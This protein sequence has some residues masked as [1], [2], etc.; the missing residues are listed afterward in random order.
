MKGRHSFELMSKL[1]HLSRRQK[2]RKNCG[3]IVTVINHGLCSCASVPAA[4]FFHTRGSGGGSGLRWRGSWHEVPL[5]HWFFNPRFC[6]VPRDTFFVVSS[7]NQLIFSTDGGVPGCA[8]TFLLKPQ[9][10]VVVQGLRT[11]RRCPA[12]C[13]PLQALGAVRSSPQSH[14]QRIPI[15]LPSRI[16][17]Q[18]ERAVAAGTSWLG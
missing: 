13:P 11:L 1:S 7:P 5:N 15:A 17:S 12:R 14:W 18:D 10:V 2:P 4:N 3:M 8:G 6:V 9:S 16:N